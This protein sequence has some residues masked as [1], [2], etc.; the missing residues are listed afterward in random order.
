MFTP[1]RITAAGRPISPAAIAV[2]VIAALT[3]VACAP[4]TGHT[5]GTAAGA[6]DSAASVATSRSEVPAGSASGPDR[7]TAGK[8]ASGAAPARPDAAG[9]CAAERRWGTGARAGGTAMT[10]AP[11]YQ[12][13]VG[14]HGCFDRV[15]FDINGPEPVGFSARYVPVVTADGSGAPVPVTGGAVLEVVVRAPVNG[16][17]SQGHQPWVSPPAVGQGLVA[18]A[19]LAGWASLTSVAFAGSF[20][21]QS[22]VAVGVRD[23]R[24]FRVWISGGQHYRH[25]VLDIAH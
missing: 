8:G 16:D 18:P 12:V 5:G 17:D 3:A 1:R 7:T 13:R 25:V 15:V 11:L 19:R 21:G 22:T 10:A 9:S 23:R 24:P 20:E 14:R 2:A 6:G 4:A